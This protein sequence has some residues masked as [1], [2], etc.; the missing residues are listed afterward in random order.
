M[1]DGKCHW[2][3]AWLNQLSSASSPSPTVLTYGLNRSENSGIM[4]TEDNN[5]LTRKRREEQKKA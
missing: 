4:T 5:A 3:V 1:I 2:T